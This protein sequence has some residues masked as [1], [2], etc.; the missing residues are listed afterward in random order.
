MVNDGKPIASAA[1]QR[2][3]FAAPAILHTGLHKSC[4]ANGGFKT[5]GRLARML[6]V[7]WAVYSGLFVAAAVI[8]GRSYRIP[9]WIPLALALL[10]AV[11]VS[12]SG[13]TIVEY[14]P[15][16]ALGVGMMAI[17][18]GL[19]LAT[20]M[21]AGDAKLAA[22]AVMWAGLSGL[23]AWV[24]ALALSMAALAFGLVVLRRLAPAGQT[25]KTRVLQRGAPVPL[26]VALAAASIVASWQ[27][28]A[29]LWA[30]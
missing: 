7:I 21:G 24:F 13:K 5:S 20:G 1:A 2:L 17:G 9:N 23:Y 30:F 10:F 22:A 26:G 12:L 28:D 6:S 3:A 8:D 18:Y 25:E 29:A 11:A 27:F 19:Y 14:W 4:L 16:L 15:S